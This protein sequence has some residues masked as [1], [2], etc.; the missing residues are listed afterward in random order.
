MI[1]K[2][3][4]M[5]PALYEQVHAQYR[6][7][8]ESVCV[9]QSKWH[10][11]RL[12]FHWAVDPETNSRFMWVDK[13]APN[14]QVLRYLLIYRGHGL[15]IQIAGD[16][17]PI[18]LPVDLKPFLEDIRKTLRDAYRVHGVYGLVGSKSPIPELKFE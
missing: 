18:D 15:L 4:S 3:E 11:D 17:M 13:Y 7:L 14:D 9:P 10:S 8:F 12:P 6:S 5:P 1:F 16:V 2:M